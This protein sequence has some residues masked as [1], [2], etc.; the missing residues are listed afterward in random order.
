MLD[1]EALDCLGLNS[2]YEIELCLKNYEVA[3][4]DELI[5]SNDPTNLYYGR[6]RK[7]LTEE[8]KKRQE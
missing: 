8:E 5:L 3:I 4:G 1:D 6:K 7:V 2:D